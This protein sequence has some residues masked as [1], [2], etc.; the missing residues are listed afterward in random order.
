MTLQ[1]LQ[2]L[3]PSFDPAGAGRT[4]AGLVGASRLEA[5][6]AAMTGP[7]FAEL[8]N[9]R[10]AAAD[11][12][13][14]GSDQ[15]AA[16]AARQLVAT[17]LV[18]PLM[19]QMRSDPFKKSM[20]HGGAAEDAFNSQLDT[21]LADR[22]TTRANFPIVASVQSWLTRS[23]GQ[24]RGQAGTR[25]AAASDGSST[26]IPASTP[27]SNVLPNSPATSAGQRINLHG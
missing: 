12:A 3:K 16:T 19:K 4:G 24:S 20:F 17:T 9:P 6:G 13:A 15:S 25:G 10:D 5:A 18:L 14:A 21:V 8:L 26:S 11:R 27:A 23:R 7:H 1:A 22:I 2:T